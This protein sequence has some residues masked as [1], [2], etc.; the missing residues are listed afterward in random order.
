MEELVTGCREL[1]PDAAS[2]SLLPDHVLRVRFVNG[3]L[4]DFDMKPLLRRKGY[5]SLNND[6]L[7]NTAGVAYGTVQWANGLDIDPEWLYEDS[8]PAQSLQP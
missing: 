8:I 7:F 2:V 4:R 3:E 5:Q 1:S 6:L